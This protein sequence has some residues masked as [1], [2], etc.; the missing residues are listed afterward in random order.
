MKNNEVYIPHSHDVNVDNDYGKWF[1]G[2]K[3]SYQQAQVKAAIKVNSEKLLWNWQLGRDL[4]M[5]KAEE[6]WGAGIVEQLSFDLQAAFP[7]EKGFGV[8]NLW[9]MKRWYLFYSEKLDQLGQVLYR[10]DNQKNKL[11]DQVGQ[12]LKLQQPVSELLEI[13]NQSLIKL[14]QVGAE[15]EDVTEGM[16]FPRLFALVP[17]RHH[18]EIIKKCKDIDEALFYLRQII[19]NSW[20]RATLMNCIKAD[21]YHKRGGAITNFTEQ[22]PLLQAELAQEITKET[23]DFGFIRLPEGYKEAQLEDALAQQ[24]TRFL[25]ELGKGFAFVGRQ[26]ELIIAGRSRRI[27]L[28]FYHIY[29]RCYVVV[30]L[31]AV[32]FE[33]EFAGKLNYYVAAVDEAIKQETD[34]PTIGLLICSHADKTDVQLAFRGVTTP[35][36]VAAYDNVQLEEI[37]K[38]L[39]TVEQLQARIRL[40]EQELREKRNN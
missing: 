31:K 21:L 25:L 4:V 2:L 12:E 26:K 16:A 38:Q 29:L 7:N 11:L 30:E 18:V 39:P 9:A 10:T 1:Y 33:P 28:L 20:S 23:Y 17:W 3:T 5:R 19:E 37:T 15:F 27:D 14:N 8:D 35:L 34:N 24:M 6:K 13:E 40:L 22:L 32:M 36:G